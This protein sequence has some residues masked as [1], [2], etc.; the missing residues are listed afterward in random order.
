MGVR[1]VMATAWLCVC[2]SVAGSARAL[3]FTIELYKKD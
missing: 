3:A 1:S 2:E